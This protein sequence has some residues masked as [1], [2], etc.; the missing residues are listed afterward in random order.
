MQIERKDYDA[1]LIARGIP[2]EQ[3]RHYAFAFEGM[4]VLI[5]WRNAHS[6]QS[7]GQGTVGVLMN[8]VA[9]TVN[10]CYRI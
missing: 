5:G 10:L 8:M 3:I 2:G 7:A 9:P 4:N 1:E 6:G